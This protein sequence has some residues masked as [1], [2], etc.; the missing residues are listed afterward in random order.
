MT[1]TLAAVTVVHPDWCDR[2]NGCDDV[3]WDVDGTGYL[4]HAV[5]LG[6]HA[7][8]FIEVVQHET[9]CLHGDVLERF[10]PIARIGGLGGPEFTVEQL[11]DVAA[12]IR[13]AVGGDLAGHQSTLTTTG[14]LSPGSGK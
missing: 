1:A 2:S 13:A 14:V 6:R 9:V 5:D 8:T 7:G 11:G 4:T 10:E 12:A 3:H